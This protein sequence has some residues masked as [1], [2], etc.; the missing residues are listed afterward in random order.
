MKEDTDLEIESKKTDESESKLEEDLELEIDDQKKNEMVSEVKLSEVEPEMDLDSMH[1]SA[2]N[3]V[4]AKSC[5]DSETEGKVNH[6]SF[7][8]CALSNVWLIY[9]YVVFTLQHQV[10]IWM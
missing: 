5:D 7:S 2:E 1:C 10:I 9:L 4:T 6:Q 8:I 3:L